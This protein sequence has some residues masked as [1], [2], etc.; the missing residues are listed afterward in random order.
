MRIVRNTGTDRVIDI[1]VPW[2]GAGNRFHRQTTAVM[3]SRGPI[4]ATRYVL[5][6]QHCGVEVV[7]PWP[8]RQ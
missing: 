6:L 2:L 8:E 4:S 1:V 7:E 5:D 3:F